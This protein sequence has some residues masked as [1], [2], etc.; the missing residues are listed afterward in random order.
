MKKRGKRYLYMKIYKENHPDQVK[1]HQEW[2]KEYRKINPW[3]GSYTCA[4]S[5][6]TNENVKTYRRYG[7]RGIKFLLTQEE[8]AS[9]W[10]RDCGWRLKKPTLD[11]INNDG[12]YEFENCRFIEKSVN[13]TKGNYEVRWKK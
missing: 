10:L 9:I 13:S 5:R 1:R 7:G 2:L 11:R 12:H 3:Y 4:K 8:T 6:C